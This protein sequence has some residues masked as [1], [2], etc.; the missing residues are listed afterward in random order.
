MNWLLLFAI[1][2]PRLLFE[3]NKG[4]GGGSGGGGTGTPPKDQT[5]WKAKFEEEKK[6][7]DAFEARM[8]KLEGKNT[9]ADDKNKDT[10]LADKAKRDREAADKGSNDHKALEAALRFTMDAPNF[11]K[12]NAALLPK[13][14]SDIFTASEKENYGSATEKANAIK[15]GVIKDF[16]SVQS[17]LDL[18]TPGLKVQLEDYLKL[19][20]TGR[21]E[22]AS[23]MFDSIFE[24]ALE[25]LRRTKKAEALS[26]GHGTGGNDEYKQKLMQGSRKHYLGEKNT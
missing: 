3:E 14:I 23:A 26:K 21:V 25:M 4:D 8:S 1:N 18:L 6:R 20:N 15:A 13:S 16:F 2:G 7:N 17:N 19:T 12:V 24:P 11:L 9:S 5:D 22:K 10:D